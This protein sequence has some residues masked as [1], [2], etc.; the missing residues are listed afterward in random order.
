MSTTFRASLQVSLVPTVLLLSPAPAAADAWPGWRGPA[1]DGVAA[2][3]SNPPLEW[4]E[5]KNV[6]F[7]VELPGLGLSTPIVWGE[8]IFVTSA[9]AA[10]GD[11]A[12]SRPKHQFL[13]AAYSRADGRRVWQHT[14]T[15]LVP[16]EGHHT[17]ASFASA[18]PVTD[19]KRLIA[20]F[21]SSGLFAY[22]LSG[23]LLWQKD[24]G[25]MR[26]RNGFGEGASPALHGDTVVV[27]WDH[28]D[29]SFVVALDADT[30]KERWRRA[31]PDEV[32]SWS[33]PIVVPHGEGH[34]VVIAATGATRGY[35][36]ASGAELWAIPGMT[37]NVVPTPIHR[38]GV[39]YVTSGF[40][41][42]MMQAISIAKA[43]A[44]KGGEGSILWSHDRHTPYVPSPVL[45]G[46]T[47]YFL[48]HFTNIL[49]ALDAASG[50]VRYTETR[51]DPLTSVYASLA[52]ASDRIYVVGRDG[53]AVV[54]RHGPELQILASNELDDRFDASP[55]I[56]GDELILR[57]RR[58]LYS[59]GEGKKGVGG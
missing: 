28:E 39:V 24:L 7:K 42:N 25:D 15:E 30:G 31:R 57:G 54:F 8:Q 37:T 19:G 10:G 44:T 26:T 4:S 9:V 13:V 43:T 50:A 23:K 3:G 22:D 45:Y 51:L 14:A 32:T 21:G 59:L 47:I 1:G 5:S 38:D 36:L 56:V 16:H 53:K 18:S 58:F 33:T 55:V 11:G 6:R 34:Q 20:F 2:A 12:T 29:D 40:R 41:G 17:E 46:D 35:D 27:N 49:T 48:R 52:A